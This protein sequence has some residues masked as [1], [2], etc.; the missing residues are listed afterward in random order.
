MRFIYIGTDDA[1]DPEGTLAFGIWFPIGEAV[2]VADDRAAMKLIGHPH[3]EPADD[4]EP[5]A[6]AVEAA[7]RRRGRPPKVR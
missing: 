6:E 3:F 5:V 7:P 4:G 1:A 2:D